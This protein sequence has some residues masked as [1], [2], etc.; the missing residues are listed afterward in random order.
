MKRFLTMALVGVLALGLGSAAYAVECA[1]DAV[2]ASTLLFPFVTYDYETGDVGTTD[3]SGQTTLFAITNVSS[4]A[5]VVHITL[6]TDYSVAILDFNLTLT[7]Y[8]V[9]TMNIRDILRDGILPS[10]DAQAGSANE[11][12]N[13]V[14][15]SNAGPPPFDDGPYSTYNQLWDNVLDPYFWTI[16]ATDPNNGLEVPDP[17]GDAWGVLCNPV[18]YVSSPVNYRLDPNGDGDLSDSGII[19]E[20]FLRSLKSHLQVSEL[21]TVTAYVGCDPTPAP[22][23]LWNAATS[24]TPP[25][26]WESKVFTNGEARHTWMYITA[27]IVGACNKDLPDNDWFAYFG[28]GVGAIKNA[29]VLMGDVITLNE[30]AN[31]SES[32]TAV[33]VEDAGTTDLVPQGTGSTTFY[34]RFHLGVGTEQREPLPTAWGFR[35]IFDSLNQGNTWIRAWKGSSEVP[36]IVDLADDVLGSPITAASP[37]ALYANTCIPYTYYAWDEDENVNRAPPGFEPPWSGSDDPD[38]VPVPN[39]FPLETQEVP[40]SEFNIVKSDENTGY[41]WMMV[42]WPLSNYDGANPVR[43]EYD[44]YQTYMSVKYQMYG[45]RSASLPA[46]VLANYNCDDTQVLPTLGIG[47]Y[48]TTP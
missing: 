27:D 33:H 15:P 1:M 31:L 5:Q 23:I 8:D 2:P 48:P 19:P 40:I 17:T 21:A 9:Q 39:L 4:D 26:W 30:G 20:D 3:S 46:A 10:G 44:Q 25:T 12:W 18:T 11:W 47:L 35:Y 37:S 45:D 34:N 29:N 42:I 16:M 32:E 36:R 6:W 14:A 24:F 43:V 38:P 7:G 41:G 13:G 28:T 22:T